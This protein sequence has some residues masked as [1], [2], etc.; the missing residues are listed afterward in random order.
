MIATEDLAA[1]TSTSVAC[2]ALGLPRA[3]L[4]RRRH[5]APPRPRAP[6]PKQH[7]ALAPEERT[8]V[9]EALNSERFVDLAPAEVHATL[10]DEG[11]YHCSVRT[12]HRILAEN[13]QVRERRNQLRHPAYAKPELLATGP[14]QVWSW[15]ITKLRGPGKWSHFALYVIIDIFS[16][17]VVGWIVAPAESAVLA[18]EFIADACAK[19]EI[20]PGTLT[21]HADRGSSMKSKPVEFLLVDLGVAKTH[22]RPHVSDDNPYSE[23]QFKTF[24]YRPDFPDRFGS[25]EHAR[26]HCRHFFA[27]YNC[28]HHHSGIAMLTPDAVHHGY[29]EKI[30]EQRGAV[31]AIAYAAHPERFGRGAP[32]PLLP[33]KEA[34]INPPKPVASTAESQQTSP[35]QVAE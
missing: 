5:P 32:T 21:L 16:R 23:S 4:Y 24:K 8:T 12:M 35:L 19:E 30:L 6:R 26:A 7:R 33:P 3:S 25:I 2:D 22:S 20:V 29:A 31:L 15:D 34:W 18:E 1:I 11:T 27:W 9:L 13:G 28:E 10:L 14:N 17:Y